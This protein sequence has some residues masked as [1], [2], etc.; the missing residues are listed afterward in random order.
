M[1]P[2]KLLDLAHQLLDVVGQLAGMHFHFDP[3]SLARF[4]WDMVGALMN[5]LFGRTLGA[6]HDNILSTIEYFFL[7]T[8]NFQAPAQCIGDVHKA[9][10]NHSGV[11]NPICQF[12]NNDALDGLYDLS[13]NIANM[14]LVVV[15]M[16]AF[17]RS[18]W[19]RSFRARYTLKAMLPRLLLVTALVRFGLP[20]MQAAID[21][22]NA[23]VHAI[24]TY[25]SDRPLVATNLWAIWIQGPPAGFLFGILALIIAVLLVALALTS[26][27]RNL[28]LVLLM[29]CAPLAFMCLLLPELH[30]YALSWRRFFLATVF[31]QMAQVLVLRL[32]VLLIFQEDSFLAAV[33]GILALFLV[34]K[35]PSAL[36]A[37]SK[38]ESKLMMYARHAEH[39]IQHA[40][41][42]PTHSPSR[43]RVHPAEA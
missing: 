36:H 17:M 31:T 11:Q 21:F 32:A 23:G 6:I 9:L 1:D 38:I 39:A 14:L 34:L 28:V 26:I 27:A 30:S 19:E 25:R 43:V 41:Q 40:V 7:W 29:I 16:Y 2:G 35:V 3:T 5:E 42:P 20:L 15:L 22:N 8:G 4:G 12:T 33:H 13:S 18:I 24:L 37:S 10:A